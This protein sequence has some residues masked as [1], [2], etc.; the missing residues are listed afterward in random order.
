VK[1]LTFI[2]ERDCAAE[3]WLGLNHAVLGTVA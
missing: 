2:T 1:L 3:E